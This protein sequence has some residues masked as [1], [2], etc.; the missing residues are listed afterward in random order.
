MRS[1]LITTPMWLCV[2]HVVNPAC[3]FVTT[4]MALVLCEK[5]FKIINIL[6]DFIIN[7][8]NI[9]ENKFFDYQIKITN[10]NIKFTKIIILETSIYSNN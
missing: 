10:E 9:N 8:H 4:V 6:I 3:D 2:L 7:Y 5:Y 1:K